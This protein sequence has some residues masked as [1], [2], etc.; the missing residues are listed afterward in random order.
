MQKS[1]TINS[2]QEQH[3]PEIGLNSSPPLNRLHLGGF[4]FLCWLLTSL[5]VCLF[6]GYPSPDRPPATSSNTK[7]HFLGG[8]IQ[9][10]ISKNW[11]KRTFLGHN[12]IEDLNRNSIQI[13]A[14]SSQQLKAIK[15]LKLELP[16][17]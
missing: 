10:T 7:L 4:L 11:L 3:E 9:F 17:M 14:L 15:Y 1:S 2:S 8:T 6:V 13:I 16:M 12:V 5:F